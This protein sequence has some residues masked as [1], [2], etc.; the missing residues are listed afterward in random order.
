MAAPLRGTRCN[1]ILNG[2][3][4]DVLPQ[5]PTGSVDFVLTDPPYMVRYCCRSGRRV[6][7]DDN[8]AWLKPAFVATYRVLAV[9]HFVFPRRYT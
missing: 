3:C 1:T 8:D 9:G 4:L 5:L 6:P 2:D 7:K